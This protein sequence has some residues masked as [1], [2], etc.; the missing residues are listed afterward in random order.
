[1]NPL[2]TLI[3]REI[4]AKGGIPVDRFM[5]LCLSHPE[6]GYYIK[7]DPFGA[8]GDFTTAPE[9][10]QMFGEMIGLWLI[11]TWDQLGRPERFNLVELGPGRGT[12]MADV[13][14]VA[15]T[16]SGFLQGAEISLM[17]TSPT[18][19]D[20]QKETLKDASPKW[21][22][23]VTELQDL[24]T[25]L[26]ANEFF[27]ALPVKQFQRIGDVWLERIVKT[28]DNQLEFGLRNTQSRE[29]L[30]I[31][32]DGT[33][34]ERSSIATSL[35]SQISAQIERSS[36]AALIFD[37]GGVNGSGD[38]LQAVKDHAFCD[39]F[40]TPGDADLTVHVDFAQLAGHLN[41]CQGH[42]T[43]Q[44]QFLTA[45]GIHERARILGKGRDETR[46][47]T[48]KTA[49][50]RLTGED[51]MG[52]L[53]KTMAVTRGNAPPPLGFEVKDAPEPDQS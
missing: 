40:E 33:I 32:S 13:L 18:L 49:L 39:P 22:T 14:R 7:R 53:F 21:I 5:E 19:R 12:L 52:T 8:K 1:M 30:P 10:S 48:I 25:L 41:S 37:Y 36:G 50:N 38:T 2:A 43:T 15:K 9:I 35:F 27:D 42:L 4:E 23:S 11:S 34:L 29:H 44:G 6:H 20:A 3:H 16:M 26:I 51:E 17:E 47:E 45:M 24:P 46:Q 31:M 28:R